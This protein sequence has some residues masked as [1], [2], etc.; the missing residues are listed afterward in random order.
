MCLWIFTKKRSSY[1]TNFIILLLQI[2]TCYNDCS[3]CVGQ[4]SFFKR[5]TSK[6][7]TQIISTFR[8]LYWNFL[9][10]TF[11]V[12]WKK[13]LHLS[14]FITHVLQIFY[15]KLQGLRICCQMGNSF[16]HEFA[17][18]NGVRQGGIMS[19]LLHNVYTDNLN[20][21]LSQMNV[22]CSM[23]GMRVN[24]LSYADDMV[25]ISPSASGLQN[26]TDTCCKYATEHNI[27]YNA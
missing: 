24:C 5:F 16:S 2:I 25:L 9:I 18:T 17:V 19:P 15:S 6:T 14:H 22:G 23:N 7:H 20:R 10:S 13:C 27:L 11:A 26:L 3:L 4:I 12:S 8:C 21:K 1:I